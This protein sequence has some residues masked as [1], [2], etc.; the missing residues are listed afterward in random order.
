MVSCSENLANC[1]FGNCSLG[2]GIAN[3]KIEFFMCNLIHVKLLS[4]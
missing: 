4:D 2:M 3:T 1:D